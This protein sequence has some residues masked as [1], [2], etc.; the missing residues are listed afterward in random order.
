MRIV[1]LGDSL[2]YGYGVK[3]ASVW[4]ALASRGMPG[5]EII[6]KGI[7]GDT[8]GGMLSRFETDVAGSRPDMAFIMG[9]SND[10]F[11][12]GSISEAESSLAAMVFRSLHHGIRPFIG[13]PLPVYETGL[14]KEWKAFASGENVRRQLG[15]YREWLL[16]FGGSFRLP[17]VDFWE[18]VPADSSGLDAFYLDGIHPSE[19]GHRRMAKLWAGHI[20]KLT[21]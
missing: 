3:R 14:V 11:F 5:C 12:S 9:G 18:C 13:V 1:C 19:E 6:N 20:T 2:T 8:A 21:K 15:R 7:S 10:I 16:R 17:V 4:T